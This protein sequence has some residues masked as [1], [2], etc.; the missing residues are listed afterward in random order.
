M[1]SPADMDIIQIVVT[2]KCMFRCSNCHHGVAHQKEPFE[3][4]LDTFRMAVRSLKDWLVPGKVIGLIG[5]EPTLHE[6]F[7]DLCEIL[8]KETG[9]TKLKNG[10][11]PIADYNAFA[12][13]RLFDRSNGLGLW[14]ALGEGYYKH[15]E[16]AVETFSHMNVNDHAHPGK[17]QA[18]FVDRKS[19]CKK[20][21]LTDA[22]WEA[23]VQTC[24]VQNTW[25]ASITPHGSYFCEAAGTID[26]LFYGG[27]N[28]WPAEPGWWKRRPED[29]ASQLHLCD[30]C[31]LAQPGPS[32]IANEDRDII[33]DLSLEK[34]KQ[35]G[36][37]AVK[38]GKY[39]A[40]T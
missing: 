10:Y 28:A 33:C 19:Y 4:D 20:Y 26:N 27:K 37:P 35:A 13:E 40:F 1:R 12:H 25:S 36:S 31:A 39:E 30:S 21:D 29:F 3:M 8:R 32:S 9:R 14:T 18:M 15:M 23:N 11:Q 38:R 16:A 7:P 6:K 2:T 22:E 34:L 5:G 17:H 24:F